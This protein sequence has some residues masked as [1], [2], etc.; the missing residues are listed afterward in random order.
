MLSTI[1]IAQIACY[2]EIEYVRFD[3]LEVEYW[4]VN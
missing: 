2:L 4:A 1:S 3:D